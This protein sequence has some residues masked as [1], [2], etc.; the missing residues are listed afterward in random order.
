[1]EETERDI[2]ILFVGTHCKKREEIFIQLQF[3]Y[4][5]KKIEFVFDNSLIAPIELTKK[6]QKT[7]V[8]LNIPFYEHKVLETHRINK[9]LSCGCKVVSKKSGDET[10]D[11]LYEDYVY[12]VDDYTD[13][14]DLNKIKKPYTQLQSILTNNLTA[15]NKWYIEQMISKNKKSNNI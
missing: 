4:P 2:D 9:A 6:L 14:I 8:V 7:K 15:N 13:N 12:F 10:T 3:Q 5:D 11:N 1:M